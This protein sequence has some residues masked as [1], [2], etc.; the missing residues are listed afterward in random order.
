MVSVHVRKRME[1]PSSGRLNS[2]MW[3]AAV[4]KVVLDEDALLEALES[5]H[6]GGAGLDVFVGEPTPEG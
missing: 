1:A 2:P 3:I 4:C 5:G 6:L